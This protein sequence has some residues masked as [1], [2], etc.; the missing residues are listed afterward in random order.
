[1][2][3]P[4]LS[5]LQPAAGPSGGGDVVRIVGSGFAARVAVLFD[6][7]PVEVLSVRAEGALSIA[8]VRTR[9]HSPGAVDVVLRNLDAAGAPVAGE[10]VALAA[11]YRF[12]RP[13][14]A[15][16]SD[17]TRLVR[18]LLQEIKRQVLANTSITVSVDYDDTVL[19]G[20]DVIAAAK[21]PSV[22]LGAPR[23]SENRFYSTNVPREQV[24]M[25]PTGPEV[26]RMRPP[27]TADLGFTIM[28]TTDRTVELFNLT[29][30][31]ARFLNQNR[32]V[33]LQRDPDD[34]ASGT[35]RWEMDPQGDFHTRL[36][37]PGDLRVYG[38]GFVVRGFDFDGEIVLDRSRVVSQEPQLG[39]APGAGGAG[40]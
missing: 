27:F 10:T 17:L 38:C 6:A 26:Q 13:Q 15:R 20:L 29:A 11:A 9:A 8:D 3:K 21:V 31:I 14:L 40:A 28:I 1:V 5:S 34:A 36:D 18:K 19:G 16:E 23:I 2:A 37:G 4:A 33:E 7:Q 39:V 25:G 12:D 32:W 22:V 24:V 35:V 30:A